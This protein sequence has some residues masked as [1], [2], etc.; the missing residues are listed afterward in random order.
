MKRSTSLAFAFVGTLLLAGC[1][2][3]KKDPLWPLDGTPECL[4]DEIAPLAG[5]HVQVISFLEIGELEDGF[6]L[7]NDGDPDNKL[8]AVG[9]LARTAINDSFE[10]FDIVIP[11]EFFDFPTAGADECVKFAIYLGAWKQDTDGD[12][13]TTADDGGDCNDHTA[14][15]SPDVAEIAG[16]GIDDNCNG[17]ADETIE[18]EVITPSDST[19]D[20]DG[21]LV[22]IAGGDCDDTN[23]QVYAGNAEVCGDGYDNDCDGNADWG[24]DGDMVQYCSPYDD[25]PNEIPLDPLSFLPSGDPVI[26][27]TSGNVVGG[28]GLLKLSA[29]PSIFSVNIPVTDDLNLDLRISGARIEGDLVMTPGGL[30]IE[31]GRLGGVIDA[32]TADK[33]TGLEVEEI[34]LLPEDTL[35]DATFAN[36]LGP[37][38]AL[39]ALDVSDDSPYAGCRTPDIDV[40]QDGLEGFCDSDPLDEVS[41]VDVCIDG[42]GNI[43][44]DGENGLNNCT[45]AVDGEGIL[46]FVDGI[47]VEINFTTMP[48]L[49]PTSIE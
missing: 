35:L 20:D 8:A 31:N 46:R 15:I 34:G 41:N 24:L 10:S 16:N 38:L 12:M 47:S 44:R 19:N 7:D 33:I 39:P 40:D 29:G 2:G 32:H 6:D 3:G 36:I 37:I 9:S 22:T 42:N 1:G 11:I 13:E 25:S 45:E 27:F 4:G 48:A 17:L 26:A 43:V 18:G 30:I 21:D 23:D 28:A 5:E 49:L 14:D